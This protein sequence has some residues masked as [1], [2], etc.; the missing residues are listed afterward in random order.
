VGATIYTVEHRDITYPELDFYRS[1]NRVMFWEILIEAFEYAS[2]ESGTY[3]YLPP[4]RQ[5]V[6]EANRNS[7]PEWALQKLEKFGDTYGWDKNYF[8]G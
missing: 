8:I 6:A 1:N 2:G 4:K 5:A 7:F 3:V